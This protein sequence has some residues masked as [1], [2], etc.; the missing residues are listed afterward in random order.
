MKTHSNKSEIA[1]WIIIILIV[2]NFSYFGYHYAISIQQDYNAKITTLQTDISQ[3]QTELQ[4]RQI[5]IQNLTTQLIILNHDYESRFGELNQKIG[6]ISVESESFSN[7]IS[8]VID[9]TVSVR[10]NLGQGS[11]AI[12]SDNGYVITNYH[13][14]QDA[15]TISV[16]T[17]V[18]DTYDVSIM[19]YSINSDLAL[20]K[21]N[22]NKTFDY[23]E[24]GNSNNLK[25]GQKIVALG[26]PAGLSF[27]ATEGIISS[28]SRIAQ[29]GLPYI[30]TDATLNPGNSGGPLINSLGKI[31][32]IVDF[33]VSGYE[34]LGFAIPSNRVEDVVNE[35]LNGT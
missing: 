7:I 31:V 20:L 27:T 29:D 5:E 30:Q 35:I 11:G 3:L 26:N 28:P 10:T 18:G 4:T 19:G 13:V 22:S 6:D 24:F 9:S 16:T 32:G 15:R 12:I 23:L 17:Y 21:I 25:A 8:E 33:K 1:Q 34:S 2:V 14:I